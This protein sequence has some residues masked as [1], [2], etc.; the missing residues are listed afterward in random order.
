MK[1]LKD[2]FWDIYNR[3]Y[4]FIYMSFFSQNLLV[5]MM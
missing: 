2:V 5:I 1:M 4:T 3:E